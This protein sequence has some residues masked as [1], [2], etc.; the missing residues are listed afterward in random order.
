MGIADGRKFPAG[1]KVEIVNRDHPVYDQKDPIVR[2]YAKKH[3]LIVVTADPGGF[4]GN[5]YS[6][7]TNA[8]VIILA[9]ERA[10]FSQS[11]SFWGFLA[12]GFRKEAKHARVTLTKGGC[13]VLKAEGGGP[14]KL[15]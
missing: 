9:G 7:C 3:D 8:G 6:I 14:Q 4:S 1:F 5:L 2:D 10:D 12:S 15:Y 13:Q 11:R